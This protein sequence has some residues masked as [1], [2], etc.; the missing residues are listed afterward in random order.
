MTQ[1]E[2]SSRAARA[3]TLLEDSRWSEIGIG[4]ADAGWFNGRIYVLLLVGPSD[5]ATA[6]DEAAEPEPS[7]STTGPASSEA[8][9]CAAPTDLDGDGAPDAESV[10]PERACDASLGG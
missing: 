2:G 7:G 5:E 6:A 4:T 10:D 1:A 9:Q 3:R 8:E